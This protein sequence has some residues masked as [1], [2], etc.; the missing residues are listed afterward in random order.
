MHAIV[1]FDIDKTQEAAMHHYDGTAQTV[2]GVKRTKVP[3]KDGRSQ[4]AFIKQAKEMQYLVQNP[5]TVFYTAD[6]VALHNKE[7]DCW[8]IYEGKIYD[9][10]EY[11]KVHPG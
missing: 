4:S 2:S 3:V 6:E 11:A 5:D 10:T 9:I 7:T 1:S 8:T